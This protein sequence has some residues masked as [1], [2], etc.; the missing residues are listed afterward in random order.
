[1]AH[2]PLLCPSGVLCLVVPQPAL[3]VLAEYLAA[4]YSA[5][6]CY[7]FPEADYRAYK[8]VVLFGERKPS[9]LASP[10]QAERLRGWA[11]PDAALPTLGAY[12]YRYI[13][14]LT[15]GPAV[16][17]L[18]CAEAV[19]T[20]GGLWDDAEVTK[21]LWPALTPALLRPLMP[22]S[23]GHLAQVGVSGLL[24]NTVLHA[25]DGTP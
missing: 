1:M 24:R 11:A 12:G 22:L 16:F 9:P 21:R 25:Q 20:A 18:R 14:P 2:T 19:P 23:R 5:M 3:H 7:T 4:W 10:P 15:Q 6:T 13:V 8:Q 17:Q